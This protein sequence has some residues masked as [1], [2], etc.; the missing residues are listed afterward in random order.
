MQFASAGQHRLTTWRC[1][2]QAKKTGDHGSGRLPSPQGRTDCRGAVRASLVQC[3]AEVSATRV[4]LG[5]SQ[6]ARAASE[7]DTAAIMKM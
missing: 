5:A 1:A 4:G 3:A 2:W 7:K 6:T